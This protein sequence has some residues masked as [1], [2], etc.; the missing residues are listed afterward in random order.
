MNIVKLRKFIEEVKED[1]GPGFLATD[2]FAT[3]DGQSIAGY[4]SNHQACAL[5]NKLTQDLDSSL[6]ESNFPEVGNYYLLDLVDNKM[7]VVVTLGD[8]QW[9]MLLDKTQVQLGLFLNIIL[10]KAMDLFEEA[11]TG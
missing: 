11:I 2:V 6:K 1:C 7:V 3:S 8:Y 10:P 9:G 4:N 5:M